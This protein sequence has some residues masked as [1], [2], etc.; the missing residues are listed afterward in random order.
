MAEVSSTNLRTGA[1]F[2]NLK[3]SWGKKLSLGL[4]D[5]NTQLDVSYDYQENKEFLK[6][7]TVAARPSPPPNTPMPQCP[8]APMPQCPNAP[9]PQCPIGLCLESP[10]PSIPFHH[11]ASQAEGCA[12]S[13]RS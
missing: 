3:A 5:F 10:G 1:G 8:D 6:D 4:S 13:V 12:C 2:D 7:A 9:M 11:A